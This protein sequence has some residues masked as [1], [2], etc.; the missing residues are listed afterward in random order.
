MFGQIVVTVPD[1]VDVAVDATVEGGE[2]RL[3]GDE[4]EQLQHRQAQRP[5]H[6]RPLLTIDAEVVFGEITVD[7]E[8]RIDR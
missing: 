4:R 6:R 1:G 3:F 5:D 8:E 7:T 2:T